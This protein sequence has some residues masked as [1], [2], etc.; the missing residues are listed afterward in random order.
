MNSLN[1]TLSKTISTEF[2]LHT[3]LVFSH[4]HN[5]SFISRGELV[6]ALEGYVAKRTIYQALKD[7]ERFE[8]IICKQSEKSKN[9]NQLGT[10]YR[11]IKL[12]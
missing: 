4:M 1:V 8:Y 2:T 6:E 5:N 9:G 12:V 3:A 10:K 11:V 7:L